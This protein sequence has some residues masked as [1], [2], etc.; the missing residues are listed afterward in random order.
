MTIRQNTAKKAVKKSLTQSNQDTLVENRD[1]Y[2]TVYFLVLV[3][4]C[5]YIFR[6]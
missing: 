4:L 3:L 5:S 1:Q 2:I 6:E